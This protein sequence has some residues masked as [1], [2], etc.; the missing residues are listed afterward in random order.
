MN[1]IK[2]KRST[3][4]KELID[5]KQNISTLEKAK[6]EVVLFYGIKVP[7]LLFYL[8]LLTFD[9]EFK[10]VIV[11]VVQKCDD[12]FKKYKIEDIIDDILEDGMDN[13]L[14]PE[15][16]HDYKPIEN[17][18]AKTMQCADYFLDGEYDFQLKR[19][20]HVNSDKNLERYIRHNEI[21]KL[22]SH[23]SISHFPSC[24]IEYHHSNHDDDESQDYVYI[25][26]RVVIYKQNQLIIDNIPRDVNFTWKHELDNIVKF[27]NTSFSIMTL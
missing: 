14:K 17:R 22:Q 20:K 7:T 19:I 9:E 21:E 25:G 2:R 18:K 12:E 6:D 1:N 3:D 16:Y 5:L 4:E 15:M 23:I 24:D 10:K 13:D 27:C 26:K 8:Y 11:P